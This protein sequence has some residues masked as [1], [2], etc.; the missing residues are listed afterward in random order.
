M[1]ACRSCFDSASCGQS[2]I[3]RLDKPRVYCDP[4]WNAIQAEALAA[5]EAEPL[6]RPL[7]EESVLKRSSL[8]DGL[9]MLLSHKLAEPRVDAATQYQ[10]FRRAFSRHDWIGESAKADLRAIRRNDPATESLLHPF[11]NYKGFLAI[12]THR[13]A[14]AL[15]REDRRTLAYHLQSRSSEVFGVDIHP[16]AS[17]GQGIFIDHATGVVIGETATVGNNVTILHGVTLGGTG[18]ENQDR[19]PKVRDGVFIGAG[20]QLLGNIEIGENARIGASSVVLRAVERDTTVAGIPAQVVRR[21]PRATI[22]MHG[23]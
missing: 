4:L 6:L 7:I 10:E 22:P 14:H 5:S 3:K 9:S 2:E 12:Q 23:G 11:M 21:S 20:A 15:W 8:E 18:N 1:F 13:I 16:A 17:L 19:H